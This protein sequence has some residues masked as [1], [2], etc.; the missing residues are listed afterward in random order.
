MAAEWIAY[1]KG[2]MLRRIASYRSDLSTRENF[3]GLGAL[4][5]AVWRQDL[6]RP[7]D[8]LG[9]PSQRKRYIGTRVG[10]PS[11]VS[12]SHGFEQLFPFFFNLLAGCCSSPAAYLLSDS[13][14]DFGTVHQNRH[15]FVKTDKLYLFCFAEDRINGLHFG[16]RGMEVL[17]I[18]FSAFG[19]NVK[20]RDWWCST[21]EVALHLLLRT[22]GWVLRLWTYFFTVLSPCDFLPFWKA[23]L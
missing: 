12:S 10:F 22:A 14:R 18:F 17:F 5:L 13:R 16:S 23:E 20:C 6:G 8:T 9:V 15:S 7:K 19:T 4:P 11:H 21:M 3:A 2:G 1:W